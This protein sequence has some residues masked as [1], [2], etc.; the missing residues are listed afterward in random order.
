LLKT[1]H[2]GP[3]LPALPSIPNAKPPKFLIPQTNPRFSLYKPIIYIY[4]IPYSQ[5]RLSIRHP[6]SPLASINS[7]IARTKLRG[8]PF[9]NAT[10]ADIVAIVSGCEMTLVTFVEGEAATGV[11]GVESVWSSLLAVFGWKDWGKGFWKDDG[12]VR[13]LWRI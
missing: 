6:A 11:A 4:T 13:E 3:I 10:A 7:A 1:Q 9:S 8:D 2:P 12:N 5:S